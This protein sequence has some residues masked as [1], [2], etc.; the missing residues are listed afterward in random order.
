MNEPKRQHYVPKSYLA[1]FCGESE[2]LWLRDGEKRQTR[3]ERPENVAVINHYYSVEKDGKRDNLIEKGLGDV[4]STAMPL[5]AELA[6]GKQINQEAKNN[7][8]LY[9]AFQWMR[10]PDYQRGV[11]KVG[12]HFVRKTMNMMFRNEEDVKESLNEFT[13]ETGQVVDVAPAKLLEMFQNNGF[14]VDIKRSLSLEMMLKQV[15]P[16]ANYFRQMNWVVLHAE[17]DC[18]FVTS[19]N[20][21]VLVPPE[22]FPRNSWRGCGILTPGSR[23][24]LPLTQSCCL[25][26]LD[27]GDLIV[28]RKA[29]R[30]DIRNINRNIALHVSRF[31]FA[32]DEA[33]ID[34]LALLA[35]E[36][37]QNRDGSLTIN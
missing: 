33:L 27:H 5:I 20:P 26:M 21:F 28:H 3:N 16:M 29:I 36:A 34:N 12:E 11:E 13:K 25:M 31:L 30:R 14:K 17:G 10:V 24:L 4:E 32:R 7:L 1:G 8:S 9:T 15:D 37:A 6:N 23:K 18:S 35:D 22:N 19:D 2:R